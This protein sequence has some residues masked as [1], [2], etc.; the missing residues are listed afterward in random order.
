[1]NADGPLLPLDNQL[2]RL[3][4]QQQ[5]RFARTA[6]FITGVQRESIEHSTIQERDQQD[7]SVLLTQQ[8]SQQPSAPTQRA[9][10]Q[11]SLQ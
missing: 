11:R 2:R 3:F 4:H 10:D 8:D 7:Q 5:L 6:P 9:G 1:M